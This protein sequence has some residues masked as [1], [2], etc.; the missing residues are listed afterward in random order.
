MNLTFRGNKSPILFT[1]PWED[2]K[3]ELEEIPSGYFTTGELADSLAVIPPTLPQALDWFSSQ[4]S[5]YL[6]LLTKSIN[7][8]ILLNR[9]PSPQ[10][11]VSF[12]V[13]SVE[14][15][16]RHEH[17]T[18]DP[19]RRLKAAAKLKEKGCRIRIRLDPIILDG[20]D[21]LEGYRKICKEISQL[22]PELVT[23]GSLRQYPGLF[24][25]ARQAPKYGL[26]RSPDGRMRY[27]FERRIF[28][29]QKIADWLGFQPS[30]CKEST[31]I[32]QTLA[33]EFQGCNCTMNNG[34]ISP[35]PR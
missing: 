28:L 32:W 1:N 3:K 15:W 29:Y 23:I 18:P 7:I 35:L 24:Q 30:L 22:S 20:D 2:I 11:V 26:S 33:W 14:S 19:L 34:H 10:I 12:S 5:H 31:D 9:D 16:S 13:N 8:G 27:S 17:L 21:R 4:D 6:L 25:F